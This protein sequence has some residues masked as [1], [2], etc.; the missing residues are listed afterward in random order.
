[1]KL[2]PIYTILL[3]SAALFA[4]QSGLARERWPQP[5][6]A[7]KQQAEEFDQH[8][9]ELLKRLQPELQAWAKKG[10]PEIPWAGNPSDL[11]QASVP[12]FPGAQGGG[13]Y[14]FGGRGGKVYVVTNLN[15]SGPGSFREACESAGPR[16]VV[17]NVAGIIH[18]KMPI[19]IDAPYI[20]IAGQTA[21]GDGVCIAG[22]S[23]LVNT[24]D[25]VIRY[26]RFRR[27]IADIFN[28]DDSL[29]GNPV[30]NVIVDHCSCSWGGDESL[31]MYRHMYQTPAGKWLKLPTVNIT[32]QWCIIS[33]TLNT[34]NHSLGGTWG[35][36]NTGFD[37]NLFACN[38]GRNPSI[39]MSY[40]FNFVNNV[41][42]NWEGRTIDGGDM[43]SEYNIIN[44]YF[45]P[46]PDTPDTAIRYR[47]LRPDPTMKHKHSTPLYGKAY[48]AGNY[49]VGDP[50][51]TADNWDGGVQFEEDNR[52]VQDP[53]RLKALIAEVHVDKPFPMPPMTIQSAQAAY[54]TVIAGAGDTLPVRDAVDKR[55]IQ[56]VKTG[57]TWGMGLHLR[58]NV[59]PMNGLVKN[60]VGVAGNGIITDINQVG[61]YPE[62]TGQPAKD[63]GPDGI[64][65]WW[66]KEYGLNTNDPH[67]ASENLKGDGYTIMDKYLDGLSPDKKI[68]WSNPRSNVNTLTA[69]DFKSPSK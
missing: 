29:G 20:T 49:V 35:G 13:K 56:E 61:G 9:Q 58:A 33:E 31:S 68:D 53:A 55:I 19:F 65:L 2:K 25:V 24:H 38:T 39:G 22:Q 15:D 52:V 47:V 14:T 27:G 12:A 6:P 57:K 4:A 21:P 30:G 62:Y 42:F 34:F 28:R 69:A 54:R 44:N 40:D 36:R 64:P 32:I 67:L 41:L 60:D 63:I 43:G 1:M 17:F 50:K 10:K 66:K 3:L 51:V 45:K 7:A 48:V 26:L 5:T 16:I 11:P 18:L 46:G 59:K 23:V 8:E 37:H